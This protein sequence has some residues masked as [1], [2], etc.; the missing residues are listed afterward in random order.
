MKALS[1]V[2]IVIF[3]LVFALFFMPPEWYFWNDFSGPIPT[4]PREEVF[5]MQAF[6][7]NADHRD[8][9]DDDF[10]L[11]C[12][13]VASAKPSRVQSTS[14]AVYVTDYCGLRVSSGKE[15]IRYYVYRERFRTYIE[16]PYVGV[17]EVD[18]ELYEL[19][20]EYLK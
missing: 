9:S 20:S 18:D 5:Y 2:L 12:A 19:L 16:I 15:N 14:D 3:L 6:D 17:W 13:Y 1:I 10:D 11:I 7:R 8:I 4:I